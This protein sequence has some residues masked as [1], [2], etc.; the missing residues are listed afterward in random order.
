MVK[1]LPYEVNIDETRDI[2]IALLNE[3][4]D[5]KDGHFGTYDEAKERIEVKIKIPQ[6]LKRGRKKVEEIRNK[7]ENFFE[8]TKSPL[9]LIEGKGEDVEEDKKET[10]QGKQKEKPTKDTEVEKEEKEEE[11][12]KKSSKKRRVTKKTPKVIAPTFVSKTT[13]SK[14]KLI[15]DK[16]SDNK[17]EEKEITFKKPAQIFEHKMKLLREGSGI[18]GFKYLR[19]D[20]RLKNEKEEIEEALT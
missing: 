20:S 11:E 5:T 8:A 16:E 18:V 13:K 2:I 6:I 4:L 14:R 15:L 3:L 10:E 7:C 17:E 19:Y 9:A 12:E 1:P